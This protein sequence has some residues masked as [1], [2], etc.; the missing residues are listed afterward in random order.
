LD[1]ELIIK[2]I[3]SIV[4]TLSEI[5]DKI[6]LMDRKVER[7]LPRRKHEKSNNQIIITEEDYE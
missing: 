4:Y 1:N 5:S 6:S 2:Q 3:S 7:M